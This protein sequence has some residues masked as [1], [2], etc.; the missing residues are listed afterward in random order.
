LRKVEK[1]SDVGYAVVLLAPDDFGGKKGEDLHERARQNVIFELGY[2]VG[3]LGR[4]RV[5]L[6]Y[7]EGV[8]LPSDLAGV[9]YV[10][11]DSKGAWRYRLGGELKEASYSID[12]NK[13]SM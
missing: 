9:E 12:L 2:F 13:L 8:E 10:Q 7:G 4:G 1:Y 11:F 3:K 6:L 5:C